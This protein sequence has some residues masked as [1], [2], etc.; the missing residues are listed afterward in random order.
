MTGRTAPDRLVRT[1]GLPPAA[2]ARLRGIPTQR[3]EP[4]IP[5]ER[6]RDDLREHSAQN[7]ASAAET[8]LPRAHLPST[9]SPLCSGPEDGYLVEPLPLATVDTV[10][11]LP[12]PDAVVVLDAVVA[13]LMTDGLA[14]RDA[15]AQ[16]LTWL[17]HVPTIRRRSLLA[18]RLDFADPRAESPGESLSRWR[19]HEL[20]FVAPELQTT[21]SSDAGRA[22]LD[23][24][25]REAGVAG[26]FDGRLK[27]GADSGLSGE[28]AADAVYAEKLRED[29]I[30][31]T[32]RVVVRWGWEQL[33]QPDELARRLTR[34]GV[35][36]RR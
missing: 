3:H 16:L 10:T 14:E 30:R 23:F 2:V 33:Q 19:I 17:G 11:R 5:P 8:L 12:A 7:P 35:P 20:G 1:L 32:G 15:R 4:V 28:E 21:V 26:E 25:W 6:V 34:A 31:R 22:R 13:R 18:Q 36:R 29:A 24:E 27:Y 9:A